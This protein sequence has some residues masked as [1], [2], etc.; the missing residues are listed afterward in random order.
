M[1]VTDVSGDL[2]IRVIEYGDEMML[3]HNQEP[4]I[5]HTCDFQVSREVLSGKSPV[6]KLLLMSNFA[7]AKK[8]TVTLKGD[9]V[10][11]MDIWFRILHAVHLE[12][13]QSTPLEEMWPMVV[14]CDK[15]NLDIRD[16]N[17]WFADWYEKKD[18]T[19]Q[20]PRELLYP[21][22]IFDHAKGFAA[23][24]KS[25]AYDCV[26][27]VTESNPTKHKEL[28]L[29]SR[30][31]R[32]PRCGLFT[33]YILSN[34][35]HA[36]QVNAAK[37]R[38]R[39]VLHR[40]LFKPNECLLLARCSCK[41]TTLFGYEKALYRIDAWP[42][43]RV[44]Q[45]HSITAILDCLDNFAFEPPKEACID[46][47]QQNYKE[48]VEV[49]QALTRSYFDG[50]CLDCMDSSKPK[51]GNTDLDYWR[52]NS[53]RE[54]QLVRGCRFIHRQPTW[55]FSFMGGKE[56]RDHYRE[57]KSTTPTGGRDRVGVIPGEAAHEA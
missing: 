39:T 40:E 53:L 8:D 20:T 44:A 49:T 23:A 6:F 27:H 17:G 32:K 9:K 47:C 14:A 10:T 19:Q 28:H 37:G 29:P 16:L 57:K 51:T 38:L 48:A 45:R 7:E 24:T 31:I 36:E 33:S 4:H 54:R 52:H 46:F 22:W 55:Y 42:L 15:Y 11:T 3:A 34:S 21:C 5:R 56:E 25:L 35:I 41:E 26:G 1:M 30:V 50:L 18:R 13:V 2:T 12:N 43:E